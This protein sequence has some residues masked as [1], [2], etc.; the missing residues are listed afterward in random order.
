MTK[1]ILIT[2][3]CGFIGRN[4]VR[5]FS[6]L[7]EYSVS[8]TWHNKAPHFTENVIWHEAD[9]LEEKSHKQ[10]YAGIDIV[11]M[12]A[13]ETGGIKLGQ[14]STD[15]LLFNSAR[16]NELTLRSS[17]R[18]NVG[19][20]VF[21]SCSVMYKN[22]L[23]PQNEKDVDLLQ[24]HPKYIGGAAM[25]LYIENLCKYYSLNYETKFT[26]IRHTNSYG[27]YDKYDLDTSHVFAASMLKVLS[28]SKDI[29]IWGSGDECRDFIHVSDL[30]NLFKLV[31]S[32]QKNNYELL[33]CGSG[34]L[35]SVKNLVE[36][37]LL[38]C[39]KNKSLKFDLSKPSIPINISLDSSKAFILFGWKPQISLVDGI[40]N[41][42]NW[43]KTN[44][45]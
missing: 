11:I 29:K 8:A 21:P 4:L 12:C 23:S 5:A 15:R 13:A 32:S 45:L 38:A 16:I 35:I 2:G 34:K 30:V 6:R 22:S 31:L 27:P 28:D 36:L 3:G 25:K 37:M 43:V 9:L 1:K 7:P 17:V 42:A 44:I 40:Q 39:G 20:I 41:T 19:H 33:C 24:I 10:L 18:E 26:V 14:E